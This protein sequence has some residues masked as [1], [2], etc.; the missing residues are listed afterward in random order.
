MA[1]EIGLGK[2]TRLRC[3]DIFPKFVLVRHVDSGGELVAITV[4]PNLLSSQWASVDLESEYRHLT[5]F[6]RFPMS[7]ADLLPAER[8][9][10]AGKYACVR[11][12]DNERETLCWATGYVQQPEFRDST[13]PRY[14]AAYCPDCE[15]VYRKGNNG[16]VAV[17]SDD[18]L[19]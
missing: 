10:K 12:E 3:A 15:I 14:T 6:H 19:D 9:V 17:S 16:R 1:D 11:R 8:F 7:N 5:S 18:T 13:S 4:R 2:P